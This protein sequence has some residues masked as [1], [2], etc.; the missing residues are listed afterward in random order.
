MYIFS[1]SDEL[2]FYQVPQFFFMLSCLYS[3]RSIRNLIYL[4][5]NSVINSDVLSYVIYIRYNVTE[6]RL[7]SELSFSTRMYIY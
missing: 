5:L 4:N 3:L 6:L 7:E 1:F 2:L